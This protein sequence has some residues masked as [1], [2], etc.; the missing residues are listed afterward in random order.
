MKT[1]RSRVARSVAFAALL[2]AVTGTAWA[3]TDAL[4]TRSAPTSVM[5][6]GYNA[7][8]PHIPVS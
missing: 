5:G 2:I 3:V 4:V 1:A 7:P 8:P 6:P